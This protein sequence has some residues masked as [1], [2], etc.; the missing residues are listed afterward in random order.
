MQLDEQG[1]IL[2]LST[3][4]TGTSTLAQPL[5]MYVSIN[6]EQFKDGDRLC[7]QVAWVWRTKAPVYVASHGHRLNIYRAT[8]AQP[9]ELSHCSLTLS[10]PCILPLAVY[11]GRDLSHLVIVRSTLESWT[12]TNKMSSPRM[13]TGKMAGTMSCFPNLGPVPKLPHRHLVDRNLP[14]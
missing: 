1:P 8:P 4:E 5:L 11:L 7:S 6:Q 9:C 3:G 2:H 13:G 14:N 12:P 10:R